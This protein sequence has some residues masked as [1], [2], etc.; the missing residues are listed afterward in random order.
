[1][2]CVSVEVREGDLIYRAQVTTSSTGGLHMMPCT[3]VHDWKE[4]L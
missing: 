3:C 4:I 2:I 1:M